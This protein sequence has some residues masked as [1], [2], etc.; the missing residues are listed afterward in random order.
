M[1]VQEH[2][3]PAGAG[4]AAD[5][6]AAA[7]AHSGRRLRQRRREQLHRHPAQVAGVGQR[8]AGDELAGHP[9]LVLGLLQRDAH[10]PR[11]QLDEPSRA[12][13]ALFAVASA[14][15]DPVPAVRPRRVHRQSGGD[16]VADDQRPLGEPFEFGRRVDAV[17]GVVELLGPDEP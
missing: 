12:F 13:E 17:L 9:V 8:L 5:Q 7:I 1:Q 2:R 3:A 4:R 15:R 14:D 6:V 16:F 11:V 10:L